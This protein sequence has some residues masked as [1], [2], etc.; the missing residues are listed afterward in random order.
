MRTEHRDKQI[1]LTGHENLEG[2]VRRIVYYDPES[3]W[4]VL[5]V[6][7]KGRSRLVTAVG[8]IPNVQEGERIRLTGYW[9]RNARYG[10]EFYT[11][12][13]IRLKPETLSGMEKYLGSGL[14]KGVGP[15]TARRLVAHFGLDTLEII[16]SD[17][18]RL[19]EVEGIGEQRAERIFETWKRQREVRDVMV[20]LQAHDVS[21]TLAYKI[22]KFY[23]KETVRLIGENPYR[24]AEEVFGIGFKTADRIAQKMGIDK[25]AVIRV[26]AGILHQLSQG[27]SEG[28]VFL[29]SNELGGIVQSVLDVDEELYERSL[30]NLEERSRIVLEKEDR[31]EQVVYLQRL[32]EAERGSSVYLRKLAEFPVMKISGDADRLIE[33]LS[34]ATS[35]RL[36]DTQTNAVRAA[37]Q[38]KISIVT[39]G[40]GT[41]KTTLI[42]AVVNIMEKAGKRV[43]LCAPTGRAA[44]R[45]TE[46]TG[47]EARTIHRLLEFN[48]HIRSFI[49]NRNNP[50]DGDMFIMDETSMVDIEIFYEFLK[51]VPL[52]AHLIFVGDADQLP[53][54]GPGFVLRDLIDSQRFKTT[55]LSQIFRQAENS[56]IIQNAHRINKGIMPDISNKKNSD[57][58]FIKSENPEHAF[59]LI[60]RLVMD[61]IPK[62]FLYDPRHD[63]QIITPM[64]KGLV[65]TIQINKSFQPLFNPD[66]DKIQRGDREFRHGDKVMQV[67]NNYGK[68]VFNGDIGF[69]ERIIPDEKTVIVRFDDKK[70]AY[71]YFELDELIPA[72]A[73]TI[74][75][76]Q[77]SEYPVVVIPLLPQHYIMLQRNLLYT[78][79]TRG[80]KLV[81]LVGSL[82]AVGRALH[83]N[84]VQNRYTKLKQRVTGPR[85]GANT[86]KGPASVE[87]FH[88]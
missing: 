81:V 6:N 21:T 35:L 25:K 10:N 88:E 84:R 82:K 51:A 60:K 4:S 57:F 75:K 15:K 30:K 64:N 40:P 9:R 16:E 54:V 49:R 72:Y 46:T 5:R 12:S 28:H 14:V 45:L 1:S 76:A 17:P 11:E 47:R 7:A 52:Q 71:D 85:P 74:H 77:G 38:H 68:D 73:C 19:T 83:N 58:Y 53:S 87:R 42:A 31:G 18:Q 65:G 48:P 36:S 59:E 61:R 41:G 44:K 79:V 26:E 32:Y 80:K 24:L 2:E 27:T 29:P 3:A 67:R 23:G 8:K 55:F 66:A 62:R 69:I 13:H 70:V 86:Q 43:M 56:L 39:G 33:S 63:I 22:Y 78:A 20:F 37:F 50:L 34:A